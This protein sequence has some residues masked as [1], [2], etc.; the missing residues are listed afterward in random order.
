MARGYK[1]VTNGTD[2]HLVSGSGSC[3][4]SPSSLPLISAVFQLYDVPLL[5]CSHPLPALKAC[6]QCL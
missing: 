2:N 4:V 1:L 3:P 6:T 5:F